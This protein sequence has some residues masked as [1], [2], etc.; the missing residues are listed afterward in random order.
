MGIG[1]TLQQVEGWEGQYARMLRWHERVGLAAR[2]ARYED[3]MDFVLV[4]FQQALHLRDWIHDA[5]PEAR[6][7]L[8]ILFRDNVELGIC[9]DI[10]NG[11]KHMSL[12]RASVDQAFS[13][14]FEYN[15]LSP[16]KGDMVVLAGGHKFELLDLAGRCVALWRNFVESKQLKPSSVAISNHDK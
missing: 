5:L 11:Y 7:D 6:T 8:E 13:I 9:R 3:E 12:S 2:E 10:A 16:A 1:M 15:P 14:V 4:L